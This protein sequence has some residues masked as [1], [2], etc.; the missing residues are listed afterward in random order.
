M[1]HNFS[2]IEFSFLF[3]GETSRMIQLMNVVDDISLE[4]L[5]WME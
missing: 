4:Y 5:A 3:A 1:A 2:P